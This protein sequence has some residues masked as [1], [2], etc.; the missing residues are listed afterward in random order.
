MEPKTLDFIGTKPTKAL[1][2]I[3]NREVLC[4]FLVFQLICIC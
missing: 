1:S 4:M 2:K 3:S